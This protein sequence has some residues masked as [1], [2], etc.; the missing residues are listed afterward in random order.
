M[1]MCVSFRMF[2]FTAAEWLG[3]RCCNT[4]FFCSKSKWICCH[5]ALGSCHE[6]LKEKSA[7]AS[8]A[9]LSIDAHQPWNRGA[10][11]YGNAFTKSSA[12]QYFKIFSRWGLKQGAMSFHC[13]IKWC[14]QIRDKGAPFF[15][16]GCHAV[17]TWYSLGTPG[18]FSYFCIEMGLLFS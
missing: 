18:C 7:V 13:Q 4:A 17:G 11:K 8:L 1:C 2:Y 12:Q 10:N 15:P 6:R 14:L 9:W 16:F 5:Q 3:E